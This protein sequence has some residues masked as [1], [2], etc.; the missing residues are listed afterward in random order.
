MW[1][2]LEKVQMYVEQSVDG[3]IGHFPPMKDSETWSWSPVLSEQTWKGEMANIITKTSP[4]SYLP[5]ALS[6]K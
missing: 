2:C 5:L 1:L 3:K 4:L 6:S